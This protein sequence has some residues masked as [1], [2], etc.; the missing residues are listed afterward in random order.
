M[1]LNPRRARLAPADVHAALGQHL[2]VDG[3]D[4][5]LDL[6]KSQGRRLNPRAA[7]CGTA[8]FGVQRLDCLRAAHGL[9]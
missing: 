1:T 2:L 9:M 5:V 8:R 6:E 4:I 7:L 3:Y